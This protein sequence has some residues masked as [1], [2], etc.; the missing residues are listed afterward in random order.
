[1]VAPTSPDAVM[2]ARAALRARRETLIDAIDREA[3]ARRR[4]ESLLRTMSEDPND[5]SNPVTAARRLLTETTD[6]R[7]DER[8]SRGALAAAIATWLKDGTRFVTP[9][10]DVQRL[11]PSQAIV[12]F[13][14][15][16]ETRFGTA[17]VNNLRVRIYP[18]EIDLARHAR[19]G[20]H[21][22]GGGGGPRLL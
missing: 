7:A 5:P 1:M 2:A 4:L 13:P 9:E 6:A 8:A 16:L 11:L 22:R 15:R 18:D 12:M 3:A 14:A 21:A 17:P 10:L 20:T 19:A